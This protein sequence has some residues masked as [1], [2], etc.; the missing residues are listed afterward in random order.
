MILLYI[1][2]MEKI[3]KMISEDYKAQMKS[4][5]EKDYEKYIKSLDDEP[6]RALRVNTKKIGIEEFLANNI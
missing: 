2:V 6:V 3:S 4:L 1:F 5:L